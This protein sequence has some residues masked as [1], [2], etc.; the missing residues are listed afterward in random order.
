[1]DYPHLWKNRWADKAPGRVADTFGFQATQ[2]RKLWATN[3][4]LKLLVDGELVIHDPV[5][6]REM[7][8]SAS[9]P[10]GEMGNSDQQTGHDDTVAALYIACLANAT[11]D[12]RAI[13]EAEMNANLPEPA[14]Q[15]EL[16]W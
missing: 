6:Y 14:Y 4:L 9:L 2:Q 15:E 8:N 12:A 16:T 11:A 1:M 7:A 5:T 10:N 13:T 3:F